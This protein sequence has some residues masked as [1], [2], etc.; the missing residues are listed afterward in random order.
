MQNF[1]QIAS[2]VSEIVLIRVGQVY[3]YKK[4]KAL[5]AYCLYLMGQG[6]L[7]TPC[8]GWAYGSLRSPHGWQRCLVETPPNNPPINFFQFQLHCYINKNTSKL[9]QHYYLHYTNTYFTTTSHLT[10]I[11]ENYT[12]HY[13]TYNL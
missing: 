11:I 10:L 9:H 1:I 7:R 13:F 2:A 5:I 8:P 3:Y 4:T 6:V 12:K